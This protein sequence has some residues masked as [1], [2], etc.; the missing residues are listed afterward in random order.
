MLDRR[1]EKCNLLF[2][3]NNRCNFLVLVHHTVKVFVTEKEHLYPASSSETGL[4]SGHF[5]PMIM[6]CVLRRVLV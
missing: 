4:R 1:E 6:I 5:S 3:T 2:P